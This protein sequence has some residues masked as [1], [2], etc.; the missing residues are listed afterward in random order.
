MVLAITGVLALPLVAILGTA[1]RVERTQA[2]RIDARAELDWALTLLTE[3]LRSGTPTDQP[4][5]GAG[6]TDTLPLSVVDEFGAEELIHWR[7]GTGGLERITYDPATNRQRRRSLVVA[8]IGPDGSTPPF[9][10]LD[11][12]GAQL[13]PT[14]IPAAAVAD[15]ATLVRITLTMPAGD[16]VEAA[17]TDVAIRSRSPG[18]NGC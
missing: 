3:D 6:M 11:A 1:N 2:S 5:V 16:A 15:C 8:E 12:T 17:S 18:G 13:D 9:V 14:R 10:Y 7:I 4:R